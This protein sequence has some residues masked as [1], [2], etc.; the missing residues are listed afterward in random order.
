[1]PLS[2]I[3]G[4][5]EKYG[6]GLREVPPLNTAGLWPAQLEAVSSLEPAEPLQQATL[7]RTFEGKLVG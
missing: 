2:G 4:Q 1:M 5:S 7:Q 6:S 3:E